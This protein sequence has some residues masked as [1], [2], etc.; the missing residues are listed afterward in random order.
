MNEHIQVIM[1]CAAKFPEL[2]FAQ[3]LCNAYAGTKNVGYMNSAFYYVNDR[4]LAEHCKS[5][6]KE[7]GR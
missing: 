6:C 5:Y 1:Q 3:F 4:D 2:R 7:Q